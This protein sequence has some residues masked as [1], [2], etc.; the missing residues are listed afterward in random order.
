MS[1][2]TRKI[3]IVLISVLM[4]FWLAVVYVSHKYPDNS[5]AARPDINNNARPDI[6]DYSENPMP[7]LIDLPE[8]IEPNQ[9]NTIDELSPGGGLEMTSLVK[10]DI[11]IS[12][13]EW[14]IVQAG[15]YSNEDIAQERLALL[16]DLG[17]YASL[18]REGNMLIVSFA[19]MSESMTNRVMELIEGEFEAWPMFAR[20]VVPFDRDIDIIFYEVFAED[21]GLLGERMVAYLRM[22]GDSSGYMLTEYSREEMVDNPAAIYEM[23]KVLGDIR[24]V[25]LGIIDDLDL[26]LSIE[27]NNDAMLRDWRDSLNDFWRESGLVAAAFNSD[28][29]VATESESDN[30]IWDM[31]WDLQEH[32]YDLLEG[33]IW[34]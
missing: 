20:P 24:S 34:P 6:L 4:G 12:P 30:I 33:Q 3:G 25:A 5:L 7:G 16:E 1:N 28:I 8:V 23:D 15:A 17:L 19:S 27:S 21:I 26:V 31:V 11:S 32:L 10:T 18:E 9:N 13:G 2:V 29:I 22:L 14:W